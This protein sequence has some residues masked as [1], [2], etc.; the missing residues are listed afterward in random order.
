MQPRPGEISL[1]HK[2]VLF[3]DEFPE[4]KRSAIESLRQPIEDEKI[5]I[6]RAVATVDFPCQFT[7]V[8]AFNP[9]PCGYAGDVSRECSCSPYEI[10]RYLSKLS[11]PI[12]DR[13]DLQVILPR[14]PYEKLRAESAAESSSEV[15]KRVVGARRKQAERFGG[16]SLNSQLS[17]SQIKRYCSLDDDAEAFLNSAYHSMQLTARSL[18]SVLK[19]SRTIADLDD[20]QN[21]EKRHLAEALQYRKIDRE[22]LANV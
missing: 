19:V 7:L 21:I 13:F 12:V 16:Q 5:Q 20:S 11:G 3:L 18:M 10:K 17:G 4:F 15:V 2:G 9:C 1:A 22:V 6:A 14:V 8:A